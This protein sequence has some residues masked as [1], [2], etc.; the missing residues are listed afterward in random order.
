ML[1]RR[2]F[3]LLAGLAVSGGCT[4]QRG[5]VDFPNP[6]FD[7]HCGPVALI[8]FPS[9]T[10]LKLG[11]SYFTLWLPFYLPLILMAILLIVVWAATRGR[12]HG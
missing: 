3:L 2:Q 10:V 4:V 9:S 1:L 7:V 11:G 12:S 6:L 8:A 5:Q